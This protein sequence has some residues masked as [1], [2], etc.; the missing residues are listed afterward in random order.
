MGGAVVLRRVVGVVLLIVAVAVAAVLVVPGFLEERERER[1][2]LVLA[3]LERVA[4]AQAAV[5]SECGVFFGAE[6]GVVSVRCSLAEQAALWSESF[7]AVAGVVVSPVAGG[8][9]EY[10]VDAAHERSGERVWRLSASTFGPSSTI[11]GSCS[12][13]AR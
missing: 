10:C 3:A 9:S 5:R 1:D 2:A 11:L 7:A 8:P 6:R 4:L 12:A 13:S